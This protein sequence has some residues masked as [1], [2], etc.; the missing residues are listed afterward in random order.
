M[1]P[2]IITITKCALVVVFLGGLIACER[3]NMRMLK[4]A[5]DSGYRYWLINPMASLAGLRGVEPLIFLLGLAAMM[6]SM[7][8][9]IALK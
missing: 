3:A 4:R 6:I 2:V 9:L 1:L 7:M 8:G 5:R